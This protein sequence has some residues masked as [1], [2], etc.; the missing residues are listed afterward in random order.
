MITVAFSAPK[1]WSLLSW[2][3]KKFTKS[4]VSHCLIG[5]EIC[6]IPMFLHCTGGGV[7]V[8]RR[9]NYLKTDDLIYEYE[10]VPDMQE[11][12]AH[13]WSHID[14]N[15]DYAGIFGFAWVI[16][17]WQWLKRKVRN[18]VASPNSMWCSEFVLHLNTHGDHAGAIPEWN[19]LKPEYTHCQHLLDKIKETGGPSFNELKAP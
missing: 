11:G 7:K 18:P 5:T 1:K 4:K 10:F 13:A 6:G 19:D 8:S 12:L 15:Y 16:I 9:D 14:D 2:G 17:A 3:I